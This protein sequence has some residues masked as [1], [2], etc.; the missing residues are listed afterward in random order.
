MSCI[1]P[2]NL[3]IE[4]KVNPLGLDEQAP[5]FSWEVETSV[6][7]GAQKAY[8]ILVASSPTLLEQDTGD[9]WDSG[10]VACDQTFHIVY[11]G[12]PLQSRMT[13]WWKVRL[14]DNNREPSSYSEPA[15]WTMGLLTPEDWEAEWI[16][17][18]EAP[19][20][21]EAISQPMTLSGCSWISNTETPKAPEQNSVLAFRRRIVIKPNVQRARLALSA[22]GQFMLYIDGRHVGKSDG[23]FWAW[24]RPAQF[25][26]T[27]Y[28]TEGEHVLAVENTF[29]HAPA[30]GISVNCLSTTPMV[31]RKKSRQVPLGVLPLAQQ[32]PGQIVISMTALGQ[33]LMLCVLPTTRRTAK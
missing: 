7:G 17:F 32:N 16:G 2:I 28:L 15:F 5:R 20:A 14:W 3:R 10:C 23:R 8:Q 11:K 1:R 12:Q 27:P 25:D 30:A 22:G 31:V 9:L 18:D 29:L 4:Y 6:R 19:P 24:I 33:A 13:C 21:H 26:L